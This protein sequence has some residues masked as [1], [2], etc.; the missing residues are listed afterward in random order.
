MKPNILIVMTDQQRA[1]LRKG[2]GYSLDTMPFLDAW[3]QTGTDFCGAYTPNPTCMPAR[4]S[5]FTGR[6]PSA[7]HVRTNHNDLDA[8]YTE[9]MLDVFKNEGYQTALC[10]KNHS[11]HLLSDFDFCEGNH[12][13]GPD[14][15]RPRTPREIEL[16][17]FLKSLRH[18][19]SD[20]PSPHTVE[21]QQPYRNVS[22]AFK[23]MD[24]LDADQPF[25]AWVSFA[26]PHNPFQVP[27]PYFDM[28]PPES[29]P[30]VATSTDDLADKG[31][32]YPWLRQCWDDAFDGEAEKHILRTRSNYHGMLRLIDDQF[33]RLIEGVKERG[34]YDNTIIVYVSDHGDFA[35]EYG[36]IR[37]GPDLPEVLTRVPM[38]WHI[39]DGP[40]Q[41]RK[42]GCFVNLVDIFPTLCRM[43]GAETPFGV[44]GRNI[45]PLLKGEDVNPEEFA[46]AYAETGFSGL[47]WDENDGLEKTVEGAVNPGCTFDCLDSWTQSGQVRMVRRGSIKIQADM[48]GT[49]F[50]YDLE[51]DPLEVNNLW[52]DAAY[53]A[54]KTEMLTALIA[55]T[56]KANDPL[57]TPRTRYRTKVHP[58]GYWYDKDFHAADPG[59]RTFEPGLVK[60]TK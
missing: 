51:K 9:D 13:D 44:Q 17:A 1:D 30:E 11:H 28:F 12:H 42:D 5:M 43:I 29:L 22:S 7:H 14:D 49:G 50:L 15:D 34:L 38:I 33:K 58:D 6:Y 54:I 10:G 39:P 27:A 23:F 26:E 25:F 21:E 4:V 3:S 46:T 55:E 35:G 20:K 8:F 36:L 47:Y 56:L 41:G 16:D 48:M 45:A 2:E 19:E 32:R 57:P 37:K 31:H 60:R 40:E 53:A 59:V 18:M 52:D 24:S